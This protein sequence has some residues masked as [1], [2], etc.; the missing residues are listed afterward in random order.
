MLALGSRWESCVVVLLSFW[1]G[2]E[3]FDANVGT[4]SSGNQMP[5]VRNQ[6]TQLHLNL[7]FPT[8][9]INPHLARGGKV[10]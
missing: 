1:D 5:Q 9:L 3:S 2:V 7:R 6:S 10:R 4:R 8:K